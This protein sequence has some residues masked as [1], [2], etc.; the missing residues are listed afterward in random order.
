[1][2]LNLI[3]LALAGFNSVYNYLLFRVRKVKIG[4]NVKIFGRLKIYGKGRIEIG[5]NSII[6]SGISSNPLGGNNCVIFSTG[7]SGIILIGNS[8]GIS[9][10]CIRSN[11]SVTIEDNVLIGGDCQI[12]DNDMHSVFYEY[13]MQ[14]IDTN[15]KSLPILIKKGAWIGAHSIILKGVTIGERSVIGAGSVVTKSIPSGELWAGNPA[16]F[17]RK[18]TK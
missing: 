16:K 17:I 5:N 8:V 9:N 18:I 12:Y 11:V 15:I 3:R 6:R 2:I 14:S 4:T 1:M 7:S 10:C 13:R